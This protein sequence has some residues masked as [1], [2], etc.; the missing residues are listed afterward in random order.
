MKNT[1]RI[2]LIAVSLGLCMSS[3]AEAQSRREKRRQRKKAEAMEYYEKHMKPKDDIQRPSNTTKPV[4]K[5]T[6]KTTDGGFVYPESVMKDKYRIDILAPLYLSELVK[7]NK[8]VTNKLP[9]KVLTSLKF[10]EGMS[11]AVDTLKKSGYKFDIYVYDVADELES[12]NTLVNTN[13][14]QGS[15][16]IIGIL[17]SNDFPRIAN[18]VKK[19]DV[20]FVSALSPSNHD[21]DNNPYFTML[22]PSLETHCERIE[23]FIYTKNGNVKPVLLFRTGVN[24]DNMALS[25]F[26]TN[27]ALE[28]QKVSCDNMPAREQLAPL[29]SSTGKNTLLVPIINYSYA[30][31]LLMNISQWFPDYEFE[32]W[33]MPSWG[34][35]P[36]LK[37]SDAFPN[38]AVYFTS[39]F[40][41]DQTTASGLWLA[42][43]Y[44]AKYG[45]RADNM[46]FRGYETMIW[47]AYLLKKYGNVFNE[48]LWDSGSAPYTRFDIKPVKDDNGRIKYNENRNLYLYRY[49]GGSF[50]VEH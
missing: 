8:V 10:Y 1:I 29:F 48:H 7:D 11:I 50:M 17:S 36:A 22:Q 31:N 26:I 27:N 34:E 39:P 13:A 18:H 19:N 2:I 49:Q 4:A 37:R 12:V 47:Y 33:G 41:F 30:E 38:I 35:M 21:I 44:K 20:N 16:L 46:V 9:D 40:Y 6:P 45:G 15:D 14:M 25:N 43:A 3:D 5:S 32:V 42:N 28:F 23:E 24:V